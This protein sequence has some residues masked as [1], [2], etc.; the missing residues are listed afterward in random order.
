[1][2]LVHA[3]GVRWCECL[4]NVRLLMCCEVGLE[5]V[6]Q[7]NKRLVCH[8]AAVSCRV[9]KKLRKSHGLG[10]AQFN[11]ELTVLN[12]SSQPGCYF[13]FLRECVLLAAAH[14]IALSYQGVVAPLP[15]S[16]GATR[17][18]GSRSSN[19]VPTMKVHR[20]HA[21]C[22]FFSARFWPSCCRAQS[23]SSRAA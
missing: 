19:H 2:Q 5:S 22:G 11:V 8:F 23:S 20:N 4:S 15:S 9:E 18:T 1:M 17:E 6:Q 14:R 3:M 21:T 13:V 12:C 16:H 7:N 10:I